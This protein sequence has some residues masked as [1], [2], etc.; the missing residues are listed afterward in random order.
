MG[1]TQN[2]ETKMTDVQNQPDYSKQ[3]WVLK[4][5]DV[6]LIQYFTLDKTL[7][8]LGSDEKLY[9]WNY[10]AKGWI[11]SWQGVQQWEQTANAQTGDTIPVVQQ[12]D[13]SVAA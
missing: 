8:A 1:H 7:V 5:N 10:F 12:V 11:P 13:E 4:A 2:Q 9:T 3:Q 6:S